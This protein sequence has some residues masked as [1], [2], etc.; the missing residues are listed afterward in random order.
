MNV[1]NHL[2]EIKILLKILFF[3]LLPP[4]YKFFIDIFPL[5]HRHLKSGLCCHYCNA[6]M[7]TGANDIDISMHAFVATV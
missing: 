7:L 6:L 5:K 4:F 3:L 2:K 1:V